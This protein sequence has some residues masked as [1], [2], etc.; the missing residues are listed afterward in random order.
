[1]SIITVS[2]NTREF[3]RKLLS[4]IEDNISKEVDYEV[5]VVDNASIDGSV[6]ML[7]REFPKVKLVVNKDNLG[8]SKANNLG[9]KKASKSRYILFLN[10]DTLLEKGT[11]E[12]MIKFMDGHPDAGASTC[13]VVM[14]SGEIDDAT[15]RGFPTPWNAFTHFSGISKVMPRSTLL[16][17]YY[18]GW[19]DIDKVHEIDALAGAFML[20]RREAGE[21]VSWWDED[22]F[23]YGED[24]DFCFMLKQKGWKI[25]YVPTVSIFHHKGAS[26]GIKQISKEKTT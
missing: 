12:H 8:F 1:M 15:H 24:I 19:K 2:Y 4:S 23:F 21:Q 9:I 11:I 13:K 22:Y 14:G 7:E 10:P 17:G 16:N 25:Y 26:S 18:L 20:V 5:V 6:Q 3:I